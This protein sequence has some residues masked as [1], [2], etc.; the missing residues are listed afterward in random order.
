[1]LLTTKV[2][3]M[4]DPELLYCFIVV[5]YFN[6]SGLK[7]NSFDVTVNNL[8]GS[9]SIGLN[10]ESTWLLLINAFSKMDLGLDKHVRL[11]STDLL[12]AFGEFN[13]KHDNVSYSLPGL[14]NIL[15]SKILKYFI[16]VHLFYIT[17]K[18]HIRDIVGKIIIIM[19]YY[20]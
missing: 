12:I 10:I 5:S 14:G 15:L 6:F 8:I 17:T 7:S 1:M 20:T 13:F 16:L 4:F 19:L 3:K 11:L 2:Y 9:K 18:K